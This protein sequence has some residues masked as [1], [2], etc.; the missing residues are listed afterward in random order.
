MTIAEAA[1][2]GVAWDR[3]RFTPVEFRHRGEAT[4]DA[5]AQI[6]LLGRCISCSYRHACA[7][8]CVTETSHFDV[9]GVCLHHEPGNRETNP[10][11]CSQQ[12]M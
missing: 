1:A 9:P 7:A 4:R 10:E 11:R 8:V 3:P 12:V 5:A 2:Y 6:R